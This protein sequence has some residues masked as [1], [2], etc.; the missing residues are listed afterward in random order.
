MVQRITISPR[1]GLQIGRGWH[2]KIV[3]II[4]STFL[5]LELGK[6]HGALNDIFKRS[7][8]TTGRHSVH[9]PA[10]LD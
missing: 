9:E 3:E 1:L 10:I 5:S 8:D 6:S 7:L 2:G 4:S